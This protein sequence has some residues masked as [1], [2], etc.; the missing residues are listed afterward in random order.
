MIFH[1]PTKN[2]TKSVNIYPKNN[3]NTNIIPKGL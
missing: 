3:Q 2:K 1:S